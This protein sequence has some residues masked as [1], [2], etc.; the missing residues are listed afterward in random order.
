MRLRILPI[1]GGLLTSLS[2]SCFAYVPDVGPEKCISNC[3]D[4]SGGGGSSPSY[5]TYAAP[6]GPSP[7]ELKQQ[8]EQEDLG[9]AALDANDR[10]VEAYQNGDYAAAVQYLNEALGYSPDDPDIQHNLERARQALE[11]SEAARE[12]ESAKH[13]GQ[14]AMQLGDE[15]ASMEARNVFDTPGAD[16]GTLEVPPVVAG[17]GRWKSNDPV[18]P[19]EKHSL[20]IRFKEWQRD[21]LKQK[22]QRLE[23]KRTKLDPQKDAVQIAK[24]KQEESDQQNKIHMLNFS[25]TEELSKAPASESK[26]AKP[27]P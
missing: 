14:V 8:R 24:I 9:E 5:S 18:V 4:E 1:I 15:A 11:Q 23:E 21:E 3:P 13:H 2:A 7:K 22:I 17:D 20:A 16:A 19:H 25:I 10:G 6:A 27:A 26:P 12:L